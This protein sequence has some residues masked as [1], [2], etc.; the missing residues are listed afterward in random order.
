MRVLAACALLFALLCAQCAAETSHERLDAATMD[1]LVEQAMADDGTAVDDR[2]GKVR[3]SRSLK[4]AIDARVKRNFASYMSF[5]LRSELPMHMTDKLPDHGGIFSLKNTDAQT[6]ETKVGLNDAAA[7]GTASSQV[8]APLVFD[9]LPNYRKEGLPK[10]SGADPS[11][12]HEMD[13]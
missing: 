2:T 1:E 4:R 5:F 10:Y 8:D 7:A 3:L 6:G 11:L 9:R 12:M 13:E